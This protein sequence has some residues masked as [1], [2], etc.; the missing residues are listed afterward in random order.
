MGID[1]YDTTS[2]ISIALICIVVG[3]LLFFSGATA[4]YIVL[5]IVAVLALRIGEILWRRRTLIAVK[6]TE[7]PLRFADLLEPRTVGAFVLIGA[8]ASI[9]YIAVW[10]PHYYLGWWGGIS[11]L[12]HYYRDVVWYEKSVSSAT[13]P[14]ASPWWSWPLMLRPIAYWQN[15]PKTGS[16]QTVWGGGNPVLWWGALTAITITAVQAIERPNVTRA[17]LVA[18]YLSYLL[19]WAWIG[20]TLFLYHYMASVYFGY[21]ALAILLSECFKDRAEPWEHLALLLTMTPVFFLGLPPA[22]AWLAFLAVVAAYVFLSA[23]HTV[24]GTLRCQRVC[25]R[26]A[27]SVRVLLPDLG[28]HPYQP[29]R[30]LRADVA[31]GRGPA[32][33]DMIAHRHR[34]RGALLVCAVFICAAIA[35][36]RLGAVLC[37]RAEK[38]A[39]QRRLRQ[40]LRG[41]TGLVAHRGLDQQPRSV[42]DA[43]A[44]VQ[45]QAERDGGRQPSSQRRALDAAAD[46][47]AGMVS[48]ERRYPH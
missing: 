27:D 37:R 9:T 29:R 5:T 21:L 12:F 17:F 41:S 6:A 31:A 33:L 26:R 1:L 11:D 32:Q 15:F 4:G 3:A 13:H 36:A 34:G 44:S 25:D 30:V 28:R 47:G 14:Y 16:V 24:R 7:M 8:V 20:R 45:R 43:L 39:A 48:A 46:A 22:W 23:E 40:G 42:P 2:T 10:I 19:I 35:A 18:G 38:S